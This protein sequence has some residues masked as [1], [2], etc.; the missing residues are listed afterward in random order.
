MNQDQRLYLLDTIALRLNLD[1]CG[2]KRYLRKCNECR[3]R[4]G[5]FLYTRFRGGRGTRNFPIVSTRQVSFAAALDRYFP[6]F[7]STLKSKGAYV[8]LPSAYGQSY[9]KSEATRAICSGSWVESF[10]K[11]TSQKYTMYMARCTRCERWQESRSFPIRDQTSR[12]RIMHPIEDLD[13]SYCNKCLVDTRG[14]GE[15]ADSLSEWIVDMLDDK[16]NSLTLRLS[17]PLNSYQYTR[18]KR[19]PEKEAAEWRLLLRQTPWFN[20][21]GHFRLSYKQVDFINLRRR[22]WKDLVDKAKERDDEKSQYE[23]LNKLYDKWIR[24]SDATERKWR[25][26]MACKEEIENNPELLVDWAL[27]RGWGCI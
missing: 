20:S 22:Q 5:L 23:D 10:V 25:L 13:K 26:M 7:L 12:W 4:K 21:S 19:L 27:N 17:E 9:T 14:R 15:L 6:G 8:K 16:L 24:K 1:D 11:S 3:F 2:K 18:V